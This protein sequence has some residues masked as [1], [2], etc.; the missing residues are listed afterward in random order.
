MDTKTGAIQ[1]P[2][3]YSLK[4]GNAAGKATARDGK[5]WKQCQNFESVFMGI[6]IGSMR[7]TVQK[8]EI[9]SGGRGEEVFQNMLD[10]QFAENISK[11][12]EGIGIAKMLYE[13]FA[14]RSNAQNKLEIVG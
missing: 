6:L 8:N 3:L 11:N 9:F 4:N 12:G 14:K 1:T 10:T 13:T 7:K 2:P 5:L